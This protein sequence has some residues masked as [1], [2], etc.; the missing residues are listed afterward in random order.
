MMPGMQKPHCM[1]AAA[2][3][4]SAI[5]CRSA[6]DRPSSVRTSLPAALAAGVAQVVTARPPTIARQHPHCPWGAQPSF[7][8]WT[9][10]R[11]RRVSSSDSSGRGSTVTGAP[12]SVKLMVTGPPGEA[13]VRLGATGRGAGG[14]VAAVRRSTAAAKLHDAVGSALAIRFATMVRWV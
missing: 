12:L 4:A 8:E 9:P 1:P 3:N 13:S 2:T 6:A 7:T 5:C 11:S 14:G 10:Q